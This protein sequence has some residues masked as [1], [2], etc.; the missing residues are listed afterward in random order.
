MA[1]FGIPARLQLAGPL[2]VMD[3]GTGLARGAGP[4]WIMSHGA[5][6]HFTMDAGRL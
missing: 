5:L 2:I 4:G 6:R 3:T 1:R